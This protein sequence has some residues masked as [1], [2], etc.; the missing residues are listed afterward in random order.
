MHIYGVRQNKIELEPVATE[1]IARAGAVPIVSV[2]GVR[3]PTALASA[4]VTRAASA[5]FEYARQTGPVARPAPSEAAP[6]VMREKATGRI[7]TFNREIVIRFK[8]NVRTSSR[9]DI[10]IPL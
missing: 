3:T 9:Y 6:T 5:F 1:V 7:R 8:P 4:R 2:R 10:R